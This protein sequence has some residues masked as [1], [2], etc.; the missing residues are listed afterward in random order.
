MQR[1]LPQDDDPPGVDLPYPAMSVRGHD[2]GVTAIL[3]LP[4]GK[5][6]VVTGSYDDHIRVY[7]IQPLQE[8]H[9]LRKTRLLAEANLGG[10]VWRLR[11]I[12]YDGGDGRGKGEGTW[13]ALI[14]ASCMHAGARVVRI[15]GS[16]GSTGDVVLEVLGRFEEHRS[17]NY[18]SDFQPGSERD[19]QGEL[20][21]VSTSFYDK[22]LCLWTIKLG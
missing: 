13:R 21:C 19:G 12:R 15:S 3:P 7:S 5:D 17:M 9:G 18:A 11:L 16:D 8:T 14:L 4:C 1:K 10:G 2:A 22:L 6:I 20:V